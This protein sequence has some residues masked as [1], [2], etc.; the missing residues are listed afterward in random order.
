MVGVS[1]KKEL[2]KLEVD[3][4]L[5]FSPSP[6]VWKKAQPVTKITDDVYPFNSEKTRPTENEVRHMHTDDI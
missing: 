3:K 6:N 5:P 1:S 4:L 2:D